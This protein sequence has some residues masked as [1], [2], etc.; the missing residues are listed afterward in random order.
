MERIRLHRQPSQNPVEPSQSLI[1]PIRGFTPHHVQQPTAHPESVSNSTE[2]FQTPFPGHDF[3]QISILPKLTISQPNDPYE[4]EADRVASEVVSQINTPN[5]SPIQRQEPLEDEE[6]QPKFQNNPIMPLMQ[7]EE[8]L[9]DEEELQMKPIQ[10]V[11]NQAGMAVSPDLETSIAQARGGGQPLDRSIRE[12]IE[13]AMGA[14]FSGVKIHTDAQADQLNRSVQARAFTT[15]QDVFFRQGEYNPGSRGGQELIAHELTHVVQQTENKI[16]R[17]ESGTGVVEQ[18]KITVTDLAKLSAEVI[19][20]KE[21]KEWDGGNYGGTWQCNDISKAVCEKIAGCTEQSVVGKV[22]VRG[23]TIPG[24]SRNQNTKGIGGYWFFEYHAYVNVEGIGLYD[25]TF[26]RKIEGGDILTGKEES[27]E[28][29]DDGD[30]V[31]DYYDF[32]SGLVGVPDGDQNV[33]MYANMENMIQVA[34]DPETE[35]GKFCRG[36]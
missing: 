30:V 33:W 28:L 26:N 23:G 15:G 14:D 31:V 18:Q 5:P 36:E 11:A 13:Q 21:D 12:P 32:G 2:S 16:R 25:P 22:L 35:V 6:L 7:R 10:R 20:V 17:M 19:A 1:P 3:S 24:G 8:T 29:D 27:K 4:Q 9:E 34:K